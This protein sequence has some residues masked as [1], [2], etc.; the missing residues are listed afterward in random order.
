[1]KNMWCVSTCKSTFFMK[2]SNLKIAGRYGVWSALFSRKKREKWWFFGSIYHSCEPC[3]PSVNPAK[4]R[5]MVSALE[6]LLVY[7]S[8][9]ARLRTQNPAPRTIF[10]PYFQFWPC[11]LWKDR[12]PRSLG[13][14]CSYLERFQGLEG[15]NGFWSQKGSFLTWISQIPSGVRRNPGSYLLEY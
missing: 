4:S 9:A 3:E 1:M 11:T 12:S 2:R 5:K 8:P 7:M 14:L 13:R 6:D 15:E 10:F